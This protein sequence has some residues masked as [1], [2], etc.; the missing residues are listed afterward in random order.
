MRS[1]MGF[2]EGGAPALHD[3]KLVINWDHEG[4][5][6][7]TALDT[8]TGKTLWKTDRDERMTWTTPLIVETDKGTQVV[9][10]ASGKTRSY[11]LATGKLL[12]ECAGQTANVIPSAVTGH[13]LLYAISG[14]RGHSL[15]AI[16]YD[17]TGDL[18]D[19]DAVVWN[20]KKA[21]PYV[22]SP[23]LYDDLLYFFSD[24][25]NILSGYE[26]KTGT[27]LIDAQ[28]VES[29][30]EV[31]ASPVGAAGRVYLLGRDGRGVVL[32]KGAQLDVLASNKLN[33]HFD[34][35]PAIVGKQL[36]LRGRENLY[37][38]AE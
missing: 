21:T 4:E 23:L 6:F 26:A 27:A 22:P 20:I 32:K 18:T 36:F 16:R 10:P 34:A 14:F 1:Q 29:L 24:N 17:R 28:R 9:V 37:C 15:Q 11:D 30:G 31:Y 25:N 13:G 7:I 3:G 8:K 5:D 19:T 12:W 35:S 33:D 38:I 2:G